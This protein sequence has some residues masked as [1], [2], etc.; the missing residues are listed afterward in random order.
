M[1]CDIH[2]YVEAKKNG[3]WEAIDKWQTDSDGYFCVPYEERFY[4]GRNYNLFS[5]LADVRNGYGF[6]GSDTGDGFKPISSPKGNPSDISEQVKAESDKWGSDGHSHSF[7]TLKELL[8][9]D[10]TQKTT[11]RGTVNAVEYFKWSQFEKDQGNG[12]E[13]YCGSVSGS[14]VK[15][16]SE[17]EMSEK[18][19]EVL[20]LDLPSYALKV[21]AIEDA[22]RSTYCRVS[23]ESPYYKCAGSFLSTVIPRLLRLGNPEDARIVFWFDN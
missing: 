23:W 8:D 11:L 4:T 14:A 13:S 20:N 9:Y 18:I 12:P 17:K 16:I 3:K 21:K 2:L 22:M 1:G 10:W 5:I 6:A 7:L 19:K 15:N